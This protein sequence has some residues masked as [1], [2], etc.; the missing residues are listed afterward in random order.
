MEFFIN[1]K[2]WEE[3][4]ERLDTLDDISYYAADAKVIYTLLLFTLVLLLVVDR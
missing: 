3:V 1:R 4:S 2:E